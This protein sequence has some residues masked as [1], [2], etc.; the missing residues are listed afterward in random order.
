MVMTAGIREYRHGRYIDE[1]FGSG[2]PPAEIHQWPVEEKPDYIKRLEEYHPEWNS[3]R[4][5][6]PMPPPLPSQA[7][8]PNG[9]NHAMERTADRRTLHF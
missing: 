3:K 2:A 7:H 9:P 8:D 6:R 5:P 1:H 4:T